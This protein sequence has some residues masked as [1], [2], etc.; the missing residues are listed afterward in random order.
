MMTDDDLHANVTPS[1]CAPDK[2]D[3][4]CINL[5]AGNIVQY[6]FVKNKL[7][8]ADER[9]VGCRNI[10]SKWCSLFQLL[11]FEAYD[12]MI[13]RLLINGSSYQKEEE[14]ADYRIVQNGLICLYN[15]DRMD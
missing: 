14:S 8:I 6:D 3:Y 12:R 9:V 15:I 11:L 4:V 5:E 1:D 7:R 13:G 10:S 2:D